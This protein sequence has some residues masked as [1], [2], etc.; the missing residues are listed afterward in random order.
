[1]IYLI[2]IF[3][4][5]ISLLLWYIYNKNKKLRQKIITNEKI[6]EENNKIIEQNKI[7][8]NEQNILKNNVTR[9]NE[10]LSSLQEQVINME[11]TS[12]KAFKEYCDLLENDYQNIDNEYDTYIQNL[13]E[14]YNKIQQEKYEETQQIQIELNNIKNT[15]AA[16]IEALRKEK[17]IKENKEQYCLQVSATDLEDIKVLTKVKTQLKQPRIL[18]MLIWSTYY[19]KPMTQLCNSILGTATITG[20]YKITNQLD[21]YCYIGQSVNSIGAWKTFPSDC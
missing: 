7:L 6:Q 5:I 4:L 17:E 20:I 12:R 9:Y 14:A 8:T 18:S 11:N 10:N 16:A 19:Q 1:M 2:F 3:L 15:R 21:D 13:K